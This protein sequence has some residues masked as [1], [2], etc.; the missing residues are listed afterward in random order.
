MLKTI[1]EKIDQPLAVAYPKVFKSLQAGASDEEIKALKVQCFADKDIPGD[2]LMLYR[3]HN[4]QL[5]HYALNPDDNRT[6]LPIKAVIDAWNFLNNPLEDILQPC[7]RSWIPVLYN[8]AGD[9]VVYE[10]EGPLAGKLI[11]YRHNDPKRPV[12][13]ESVADWA[14]EVLD[15]A[16]ES[17]W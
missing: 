14:Q 13:H 10:T 7:S 5:G 17:Q 12:L 4:G 8:G 3:W 1:L 6:F 11:G 15:V 16:E 2:L 9:Y